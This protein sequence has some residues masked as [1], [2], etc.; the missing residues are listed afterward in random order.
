MCSGEAPAGPQQQQSAGVQDHNQQVEAEQEAVELGAEVQPV[1]LGRR[2]LVVLGQGQA[3][4][5]QLL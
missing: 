3:E 4:G 2:L 5:G 1:S